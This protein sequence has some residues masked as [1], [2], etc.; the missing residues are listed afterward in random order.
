LIDREPPLI[1][2]LATNFDLLSLMGQVGHEDLR[3][4]MD[5]Y[6]Q[7][8]QRVKLSTDARSTSS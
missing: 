6:A 1:A 5:V 2:L 4:K 7:L 8:Q 3:M